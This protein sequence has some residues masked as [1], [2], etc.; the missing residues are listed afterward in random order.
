LERLLALAAFSGGW[1]NIFQIP[2]VIH[3][4]NAS[5]PISETEW[6]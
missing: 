3:S 6:N 4:I 2:L 1:Q 5:P